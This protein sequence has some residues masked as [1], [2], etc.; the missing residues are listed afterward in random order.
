MS[1]GW[2]GRLAKAFLREDAH[3]ARVVVLDTETSGLDPQRDELLAIGAVAV[4]ATGIRVEDSFEAV[5]RPSGPVSK[6][7]IVVHGI[8]GEMQRDG[9]AP[10]DALEAFAAYAGEA[11]LIAFHASFDRAILERAFAKAGVPKL[12]SAWLDAAHLAATLFPEEN[13]RGTRALDD[14][15]TRFGIGTVARHSAAGDAVVTAELFLRLRALAVK[16]GH[17]SHASLARFAQAHRWL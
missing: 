7:S 17:R 1:D 14:W 11:P 13:K 10:R 2:R 16:E 5:L 15:L 3:D 12:A 4:D 9:A 6:D 8:G